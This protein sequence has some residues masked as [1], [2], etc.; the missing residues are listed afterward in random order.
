MEI[1]S[2]MLRTLGY[3]VTA[4]TDALEAWACFE[5][6]PDTFDLLVTDLTM[7]GLTGDQL[8]EKVVALRPGFPVIIT[9]G[10]SAEMSAIIAKS[11]NIRGYIPKPMV[12]GELAH[13]VRQALDSQ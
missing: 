7:P 9:T 2:E 1:G 3:T 11:K 6:A 5:K 4:K 12:L 8:A 13:S 10:N